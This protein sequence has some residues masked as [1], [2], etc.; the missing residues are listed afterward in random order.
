V[1]VKSVVEQLGE[2]F[3]Y[4]VRTDSGKVTQQKVTL[5]QQINK[6]IIIKEGL[7]FGDS[8]V[9]EG[10]QN[11]KEGSSIMKQQPAKKVSQ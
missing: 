5:G 3:V 4:K 1:P 11:L 8:I 6:Q 7:Q 10:V 9:V 2:F